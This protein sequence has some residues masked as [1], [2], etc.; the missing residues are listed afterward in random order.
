MLLVT[1]SSLFQTAVAFTDVS[2]MSVLIIQ[3]RGSTF[4]AG[5]LQMLRTTG[6]YLPQIFSIRVGEEPYKRNIFLK[7]TAISRCCL[8]FAVVPALFLKDISRVFLFVFLSLTF[9]HV[10]DGFTIVP[11]LE[12]VAKSFPAAKRGTLFGLTQFIGGIGSIVA[13]FLVSRILTNVHF[14]FPFNY[15]L[16]LLLELVILSCGITFLFLL[17]EQ[18]DE[19]PEN[20]R[21]LRQSLAEIPTLIRN[22]K[23][24]KQLTVLQL[25]ISFFSM[26]TPFYSSYALSILNMEMSYV[27]VF[28]SLQMVGRFAF[29]FIWAQLCNKKRSKQI[30]QFS[31]LMFIIS[32]VFA[33]MAQLLPLSQNV[34]NSLMLTVFFLSGAATSG[35]FLGMNTFV[36]EIAEP[37]QRSIILGFLNSLNV[38]TSMLPLIAGILI[39]YAS[40]TS[41]FLIASVM[42]CLGLIVSIQMKE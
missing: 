16:L 24:I 18:P 36:M 26:A 38:A 17:Q 39:G 25:L 37:K 35:V 31:S 9:F 6:L 20:T 5:L 15:G 27:G 7:W 13:G 21:S 3:A 12:F 28:L 41:V 11:W 8:V 10:F 29:S 33:V 14:S 30:I 2:V 19:T 42:I 23:V 1:E 34:S 22:N 40:Y 4:L 32:S